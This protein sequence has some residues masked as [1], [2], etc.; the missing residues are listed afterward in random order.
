LV[1]LIFRKLPEL[2]DDARTGRQKLAHA[3][4]SVIA[5]VALAGLA[6]GAAGYQA[7]DP[8][9]AEQ[10]RLSETEK[11]GNNVV[12]VILTDFRAVD[13]LGEITV[14]SLAALGIV[15]LHRAARRGDDEDGDGP[16]AGGPSKDADE[17][18]SWT[19]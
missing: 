19:R 17:G 11:R 7:P 1:L 2:G 13:T 9:G 6:W 16:H 15:A 8:A 14:V 5:G 10:L 18:A 3:T 4:V 12:N